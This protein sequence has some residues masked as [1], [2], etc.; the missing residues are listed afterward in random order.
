MTRSVFLGVLEGSLDKAG[1]FYTSGK[2]YINQSAYQIVPPRHCDQCV[3]SQQ[4]QKHAPCKQHITIKYNTMYTACSVGSIRRSADKL[5]YLTELSAHI[6]PFM[7]RG[8]EA[9]AQIDRDVT[10]EWQTKDQ[11][12]VART[13]RVQ[14]E[15]PCAHT[16]TKDQGHRKQ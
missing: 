3:K 8:M 6:G 9:V 14:A 7:R 11:K 15:T 12:I 5:P 2:G 13:L 1:S 4:Q 10:E 16:Q